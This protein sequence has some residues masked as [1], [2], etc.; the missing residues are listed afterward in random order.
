MAH[1]VRE[2][3]RKV[4]GVVNVKL[5]CTIGSCDLTAV[6]AVHTS[7]PVHTDPIFSPGPPNIL[8]KV[9]EHGDSP[10]QG[11]E[12]VSDGCIAQHSRD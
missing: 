5:V 12:S 6:A 4:Q 1:L 8:L 3:E 10:T 11:R 2:P 9:I 7:R